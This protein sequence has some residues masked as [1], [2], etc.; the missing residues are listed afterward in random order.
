MTGEAGYRHARSHASMDLFAGDLSPLR[1]RILV[2]QF[3]LENLFWEGASST[4]LMALAGQR[5]RGFAR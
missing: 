2:L 3:G 4:E 5:N 1:A